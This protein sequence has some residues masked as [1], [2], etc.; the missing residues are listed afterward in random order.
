M[1]GVAAAPAG[2]VVVQVEVVVRAAPAGADRLVP[3]D[4]VPRERRH[5]GDRINA[6]ED[7]AA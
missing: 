2:P 3:Q 1:A 4:Q 5:R 6:H 7:R